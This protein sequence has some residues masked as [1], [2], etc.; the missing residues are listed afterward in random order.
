LGALKHL[1]KEA[2]EAQHEV[3]VGAPNSYP[4]LREEI[5][6]CLSLTFDAARRS[7]LSLDNLL[8]IAFAKLEKNRT[9]VWTKPT[10]SDEPI[11]HIRGI[12]D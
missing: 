8:D 2:R 9:R 6:D 10:N 5:A 3:G 12:N 1:E 7:G 11:E 4:K